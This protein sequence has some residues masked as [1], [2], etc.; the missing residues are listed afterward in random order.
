MSMD[1]NLF[2][3]ELKV[4]EVIWQHSSITASDIAKVLK[5]EIGWN[6]NTTYTVIKKC[7]Q[8]E[9][10]RREEPNFICIA[11]LSREQAQQYGVATL[12]RKMYKGN[13]GSFVSTFAPDGILSTKQIEN[14]QKMIEDYEG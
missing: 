4:M 14:L 11:L 10:I 8:K 3:S 2:D 6:R 13:I 12:I 5:E 1:M 7:I 9:V